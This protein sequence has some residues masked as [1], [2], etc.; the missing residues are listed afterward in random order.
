MSVD[1]E[2]VQK[3]LNEAD[4]S[5]HGESLKVGSG[6]PTRTIQ[7]VAEANRGLSVE[8]VK[9]YFSQYRFSGLD[10]P[11]T[12]VEKLQDN[13]YTVTYQSDKCMYHFKMIASE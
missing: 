3:K 8:N 11:K 7:V 12:D 1:M 9:T 5:I 6:K 2:M 13:I 4:F 10:P